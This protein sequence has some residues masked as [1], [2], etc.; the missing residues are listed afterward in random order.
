MCALPGRS[1]AADADILFLP[2]RAARSRLPMSGI[3]TARVIDVHAH[4]VLEQTLGQAGAFGPTMGVNPDGSPFYAIGERYRLNGV[5]Y[6]GSPFMDP[7][8]RIRRM[9]ERGIDVQVVS[10]N[11][12][13]YLHF[14][15][16]AD[17][18]HFC[19]IHNDAVA[20]IVKA[21]PDRLA[22]FA[23]LPMQDP[24]AA[25]DELERAVTG[26]GLLGGYFGTDMPL[27]L[28]HAA[29]DPLYARAARLDVPLLIH[30]GPAGIDG[31]P[32]DPALRRFELDIVVGFAAQETLAIA[33]L[34]F[35]EVLHRHP[36]LDICVSHGGGG[37]ALLRGRLAKAARKRAW[38]PD[39]LR[40]DGAFEA[41]LRRLWLDVHL[42][43]PQA[44]ALLAEVVGEDHLVYGTNFA[45]WD[46][47][48]RA[49]PLP[50]PALADNARRL[51]RAHR[52]A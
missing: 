38:V 37:V 42:D 44:Q 17:A 8:V 26:L 46:E 45:G 25:P 48:E 7:G 32:G 13:T 34:I 1:S 14:I 49:G 20:A 27:P 23:A 9:D 19:R 22:G 4:I 10:P 11:P 35:G 18:L 31:P 24:A 41:A 39:H 43:H 16:A 15:P 30:P 12:L 40:P 5:R 6:A 29:F 28:D 50:P 33:T 21:A 2:P 51:L 3:A 47:P 36:R 52:I